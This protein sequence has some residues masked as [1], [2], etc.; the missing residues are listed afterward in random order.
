M[1]TI[2]P[3]TPLPTISGPVTIDGYTQPGASPN[4]NG[5]GLGTN[6][7]ILIELDGTE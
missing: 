2:V 7:V 6:A 4:T 1:H 5:P 3:A